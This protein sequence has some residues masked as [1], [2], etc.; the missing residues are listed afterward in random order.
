MPDL[1]RLVE[2]GVLW[3]VLNRPQVGN[4]LDGSLADH[5]GVAIEDAQVDESVRVVVLTGSGTSFCTG[6]DIA[7]E[8]AHERLDVTSL[9]RANR[10]IRAITGLDKPVVAAVNGVAAGV[11]A[12]IAFA[13]D[14]AI[15]TESASFVLSFA[16][17]GLMP[18]GGATATVTA[19]VGRAR[20]MRMALLAEP[21]PAAEAHAAGLVSHVVPDGDFDQA[22]LDIAARLAVGPPLGFAAT[23][24]AVN[25]AALAGLEEALERER[26]GQ[27]IR[28][29]TDDAIEGLTAFRERRRPEF[30]GL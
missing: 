6:A 2:D 5:L 15:A 22:V 3:L 16:A 18:D 19:A 12:S 13:C 21:L 1:D 26:T 11:G 24:R 23:K 8:D 30:R 28:L 25:T 29:R 9:D 17:V 14:L 7:A 27:S 4:A 10:I 20:A